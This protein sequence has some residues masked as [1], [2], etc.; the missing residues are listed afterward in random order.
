VFE[1]SALRR[2]FRLK[3]DEIKGDWKKPHNEELHNLYSSPNII[4][5]IKSRRARWARHVPPMG[6]NK[7]AC[8]ILKPEE[9]ETT[10]NTYIQYFSSLCLRT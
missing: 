8:R 7:N 2:I 3:R 1:N 9:I 6:E 4:I 10:R 5:M